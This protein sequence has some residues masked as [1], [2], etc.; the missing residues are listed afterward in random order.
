MNKNSSHY[1]YIIFAQVPYH[2][3]C[4]PTLENAGKFCL[5]LSHSN[6]I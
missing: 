6:R 1:R 3:N 2:P 4:L 5:R